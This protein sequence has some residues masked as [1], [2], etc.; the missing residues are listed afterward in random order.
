MTK[1]KRE[2]TLRREAERDAEKLGDA[3]ERLAALEPGGSPERPIRVESAS[4]V[5][6]RVE[7]LRCPRC[8]GEL[9]VNEHAAKTIR[10]LALREVDARCKRCAH[11][12]DVWLVI[13]RD[14]H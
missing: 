11:R 13:A 8:D 3:R 7:S 1:K 9:R 5:E 2:R 10:G 6:L 12:R 4:Q 14:L